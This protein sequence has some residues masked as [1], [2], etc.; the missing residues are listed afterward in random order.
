M[1]AD[2]MS[3]V[4]AT[5]IRRL[6][7][8]RGWTQRDLMD[9]LDRKG[10]KWSRATA[11]DVESPD[12]R[13][14]S[15]EELLVLSWVFGKPLEVL[16][17]PVGDDDE[18]RLTPDL[19]VT[20]QDVGCLIAKGE[21]AHGDPDALLMLELESKIN[22]LEAHIRWLNEDLRTRKTELEEREAAVAEVEAEADVM[23]AELVYLGEKAY[24]EA[25][26]SVRQVKSRSREDQ[27]S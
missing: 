27:T 20:A 10:L 26:A 9:E 14:V 13:K 23:R 12:R 4:I 5:N 25:E 16:L 6:R 18:V 11:A 22:R 15:I 17:R 24:R 8:E 1:S 3:T 19:T 2:R 7:L 21:A